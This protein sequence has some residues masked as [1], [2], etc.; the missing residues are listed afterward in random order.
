MKKK[1]KLSKRNVLDEFVNHGLSFID[2]KKMKPFK[3]VVDTGNG[4][5]GHFMPS[6]EKKLPWKVTRLFYEL[7]GTFPNHIPSPIEEKNRQDCINKVKELNADFGMVFDGDGDRVYLIDEKGE[8]MSGTVMTA[9]IAEFLLKK[10]PKQNIL[11]N[12][13]VGRVVPEVIKKNG[14]IPVRVKVGH[15]LIKEAMRKQNGLFCGEH[16]GHYYFRDNYYADSAIIAAL[17]V[18]ELLSVE[19]VKLSELNKKYDIY[20]STLQKGEINFIVKDKEGIMKKI[21]KEYKNSANTIDWLDGVSLWFKDFW[22]NIRPSN[23]E[24][25]LRLNLEADNS[26]VFEQK[27]K[28]FVSKIKGMGGKIKE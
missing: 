13:V 7:D 19:G 1:G 2:I 25:L 4:M 15:T 11:Y 18:A 23:T 6:F 21:E 27:V 14:G 20:P 5:A 17:I 24:P 26:D 3:I 9:L 16:S 22:I 12:A 10:N 8:T 28:E